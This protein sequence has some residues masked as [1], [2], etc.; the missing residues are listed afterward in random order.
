MDNRLSHKCLS[1]IDLKFIACICMFID[2]L[3]YSKIVLNGIAT[4]I[5]R[6]AFPI[7]AFQIVEGYCHTS[8]L[9][10]Y[11]FRLFLFA[12]TSEIPYDLF[13]K[14]RVVTLKY[15]NVL[16]T[17]LL[18]LIVIEYLD[19]Y[20]KDRTR[21]QLVIS[22]LVIACCFI[23]SI[24]FHTDYSYTGL[25]TVVMFYLCRN[26]K[27]K[28]LVEFILLLGICHLNRQ[29][30]I[31]CWLFD[32]TFKVYR[33]YFAVFSLVIIYLYNE[34]LKSKI[35]VLNTSIIKNICYWFYPMHMLFI[36]FMTLMR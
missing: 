12:L 7:F 9:R 20:L 21:K 16:F 31:Y 22:F 32:L 8:N 2:H 13:C 4:L 23:C 18:G 24:Y 28:Y 11:K 1:Y 36:Y 19:K 29:P 10:K 6:L 34:R 30:L 3:W 5:G 35:S 25:L 14:G 26:T 17:L 27:F 33:C 15:Q